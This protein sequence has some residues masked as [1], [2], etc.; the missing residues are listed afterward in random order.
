MRQKHLHYVSSVSHNNLIKASIE[1]ITYYVHIMH[2][3]SRHLTYPTRLVGWRQSFMAPP[4]NVLF[5]TYNRPSKKQV[6]V[7]KVQRCIYLI[8]TLY[9]TSYALYLYLNVYTVRCC[10][11]DRVDHGKVCRFFTRQCGVKG[12]TASYMQF[13]DFKLECFSNKGCLSNY[14]NFKI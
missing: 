2:C 12:S 11:S 3:I 8:A 7:H 4:R 13:C 14:F 6:H 5:S 10:V 1:H 9:F